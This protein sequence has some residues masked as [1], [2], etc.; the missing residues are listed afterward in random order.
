MAAYVIKQRHDVPY[1]YIDPGILKIYKFPSGFHFGEMDILN[2]ED[3]QDQRIFTIKAM[4]D[5]EM[6]VLKKSVM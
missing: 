4:R 6:L 5:C 3:N 1:I 2:A